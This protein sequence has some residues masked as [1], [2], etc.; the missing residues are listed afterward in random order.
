MRH[1]V[2]TCHMLRVT[3]WVMQTHSNCCPAVE[4]ATNTENHQNDGASVWVIQYNSAHLKAL[5][6]MYVHAQ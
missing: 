1:P 2:T 6:L 3:D 4:A 5:L